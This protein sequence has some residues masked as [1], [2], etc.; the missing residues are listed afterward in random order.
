MTIAV[1]VGLSGGV[2]AARGSSPPVRVPV[3]A[4]AVPPTRAPAPATVMAP[5]AAATQPAPLS[6]PP[7]PTVEAPAVAAS[8]PVI[9]PAAQRPA[10]AKRPRPANRQSA[11]H[12]STRN[13]VMVPTF[14]SSA[15]RPPSSGRQ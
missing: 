13:D 3:A 9:E 12:H 2:I 8:E 7:S 11:R 1:M 5:T 6:P 4:A 15:P 10:V 14:M